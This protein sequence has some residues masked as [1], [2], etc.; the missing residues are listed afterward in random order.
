MKTLSFYK[1]PMYKNFQLFKE[2][3]LET[4]NKPPA[5]N[6]RNADSLDS[7]SS[8]VRGAGYIVPSLRLPWTV[9]F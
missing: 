1:L 4:S 7:V 8:T 5:T 3:W 2:K 6:C 9:M